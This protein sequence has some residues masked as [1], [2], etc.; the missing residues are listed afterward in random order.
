MNMRSRVFH[1]F[2]SPRQLEPVK[3]PRVDDDDDD[4]DDDVSGE[5]LRDGFVIII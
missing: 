5:G 4:D 2:I 1:G 3:H